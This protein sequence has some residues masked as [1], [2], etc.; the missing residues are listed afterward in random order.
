MCSISPEKEKNSWISL[1]VARSETLFTW[2]LLVYIEFE[3]EEE[4][5]K[6]KL[7]ETLKLKNWKFEL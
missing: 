1:S 5:K 7:E 4:K 6:H 2:T 3:E